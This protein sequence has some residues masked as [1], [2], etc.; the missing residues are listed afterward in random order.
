MAIALRTV[1]FVADIFFFSMGGFLCCCREE[2]R[3]DFV[4]VIF[5]FASSLFF[6]PNPHLLLSRSVCI[7]V[8]V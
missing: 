4:E 1:F 3:R 7:G 8:F 2:A 6:S 5:S